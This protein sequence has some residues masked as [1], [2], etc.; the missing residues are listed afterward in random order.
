MNHHARVDSHCWCSAAMHSCHFVFGAY[1]EMSLSMGPKFGH[2]WSLPSSQVQ[3][4]LVVCTY[5][6]DVPSSLGKIHVRNLYL[7]SFLQVDHVQGVSI[8]WVLAI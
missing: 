6:R 4:P 3:M 2:N 1:Y 5:R 7:L 8:G